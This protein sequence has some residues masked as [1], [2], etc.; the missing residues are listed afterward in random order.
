M[1]V[2]L[3]Y[4]CMR[5]VAKH[6]RSARVAWSDSILPLDGMLVHHRAIP[7]IKFA[8]TH[9]YT[10][11]ERGTVR[12]IKCVLVTQEHNT[13]SLAKS[14]TQTAWSWD[15]RTDHDVTTPPT[16]VLKWVS[17]LTFT[18]TFNIFAKILRSLTDLSYTCTCCT[19]GYFAEHQ[20]SCTEARW[21]FMGWWSEKLF[22][23]LSILINSGLKFLR[24]TKENAFIMRSQSR[25]LKRSS[26]RIWPPEEFLRGEIIQGKWRNFHRPC[27][28]PRSQ[29]LS[30]LPPERGC[31]VL[32]FYQESSFTFASRPGV[33]PC[34]VWPSLRVWCA[35]LSNSGLCFLVYFIC[36]R[37]QSPKLGDVNRGNSCIWLHLLI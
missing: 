20:I 29:A 32:C 19:A 4:G 34:W 8:G 21:I 37:T 25:I 7:N 3:S 27:A 23:T 22:H 12:D 14:W 17:K 31:H 15:E 2:L 18:R 10:W 35:F 1:R 24:S 26:T 9:L 36:S 5:E 16:T 28:Q 6:E 13:M 30:S 33:L 11:V